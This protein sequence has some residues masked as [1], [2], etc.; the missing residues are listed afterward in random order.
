MIVTLYNKSIGLGATEPS[1]KQI[2][3][4]FTRIMII[5][6]LVASRSTDFPIPDF[7]NPKFTLTYKHEHF[8]YVVQLTVK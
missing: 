6:V 5:F 4:W 3:S 8:W 2:S 7:T 1:T